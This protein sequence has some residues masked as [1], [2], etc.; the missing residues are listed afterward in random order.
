[1]KRTLIALMLSVVVLTIQAQQPNAK[2]L[3]ILE[4]AIQTALATQKPKPGE[5]YHCDIDGKATLAEYNYLKGHHKEYIFQQYNYQ[6][7]GLESHKWKLLW[8]EFTPA[9]DYFYYIHKEWTKSDVLCSELINTGKM[10]TYNGDQVSTTIKDVKHKF[11]FPIPNVHWSGD[12]KNGFIDGEGAGIVC[13]DKEYKS[14]YCVEGTFKEGFPIGEVECRYI[15][16]T[17]YLVPDKNSVFKVTLSEFANGKATMTDSNGDMATIT[18]DGYGT[19]LKRKEQPIKTKPTEKKPSNTVKK[20]TKPSHKDSVLTISVAGVSFK[21]VYVDGGHFKMG[22][23]KEFKGLADQFQAQRDIQDV[24]LSPYL[25]GET[26]VTQEL[27]QAV[28]GSNPS[29]WKGKRRPVESV[30]WDDCQE[31]VA[32]LNQL[33]GKKFRLPT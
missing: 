20:Q 10:W 12:V 33:T 24:T 22:M 11:F 31:F 19:L 15:V 2:K 6:D 27:W 17:D 32:K 3:A 5:L 28:M 18:T 25:I 7:K 8:F 1:M 13:I 21:M 29:T 26:E 23:R 9:E 4:K 16:L 14:F 30:S